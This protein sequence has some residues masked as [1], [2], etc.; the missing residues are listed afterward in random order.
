MTKTK[1][2]L[3]ESMKKMPKAAQTMFTKVAK[4]QVKAGHM[5]GRA[6]KIAWG[7]IK[8][9]FTPKENGTWVART[10]SFTTTKYF[11]FMATPAEQFIERTE[12]GNLVQNYI[13]TDK[14]PDKKGTKPTE[15]MLT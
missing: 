11:T 12:N 7:V 15:G 8:N 9:K 14:Y 10:D 1:M 4:A 2:E 3:P 13:L 6:Q 5:E